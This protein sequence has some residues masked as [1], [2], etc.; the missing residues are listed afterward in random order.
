M[1][2][3]KHLHR[4]SNAR[5]R[6]L[7]KKPCYSSGDKTPVNHEFIHLFICLLIYS[8][9]YSIM[10]GGNLSSARGKPTTIHRLLPDFPSLMVSLKCDTVSEDLSISYPCFV[11]VKGIFEAIL[12][13]GIICASQ[14]DV[15]VAGWGNMQIYYQYIA[16]GGVI[17]KIDEK[18]NSKICLLLIYA[19]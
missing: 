2:R 13:P 19:W 7:T 14:A 9:L 11:S 17:I 5:R 3:Q 4:T 16:R 12:E 8:I 15:H 6:V 10:M 1:H 18:I